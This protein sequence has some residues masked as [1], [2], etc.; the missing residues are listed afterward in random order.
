MERWKEVIAASPAESL[1][2]SDRILRNAQCYEETAWCVSFPSNF[3]LCIWRRSL[4]ASL[5]S[6]W[7][8]H[9]HELHTGQVTVQE[10]HLWLLEYSVWRREAYIMLSL[11]VSHPAPLSLLQT[12]QTSVT[13]SVS[14]KPNCFKSASVV[15]IYLEF[16]LTEWQG[17]KIRCSALVNNKYHWSQDEGWGDWWLCGQGVEAMVQRQIAANRPPLWRKPSAPRSGNMSLPL[18]RHARFTEILAE[19]RDGKGEWGE[20]QAG[21]ERKNAGIKRI[22]KC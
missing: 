16:E 5:H 11:S 10:A 9:Y 8:M 22:K 2:R 7:P 6:W 21:S 13:F 17:R 12:L 14:N 20:K 18:L 19:R 15:T 4:Y 3:S 1:I